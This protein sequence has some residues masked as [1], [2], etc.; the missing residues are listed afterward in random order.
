MADLRLLFDKLADEMV[1]TGEVQPGT[2]MGFPCLRVRKHYIACKDINT[3]TLIV[4][5]TKERVS[6]LVLRGSAEVFAPAGQ[7]FP[8]WAKMSLPDEG[9]W[10]QV[11]HEARK[12]AEN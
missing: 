1:D 7:E 10:R 2:M 8:Q 5:L 6:E 12:L 9:L 4:R 3:G 11:L